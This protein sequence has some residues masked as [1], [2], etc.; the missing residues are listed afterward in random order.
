MTIEAHLKSLEQK[1]V[2]LE[3]ELHSAMASPSMDDQQIAEI[4]RRKLRLKDEMERLKTR[5]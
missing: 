4:K 5:H 3:K 1:H 2:A